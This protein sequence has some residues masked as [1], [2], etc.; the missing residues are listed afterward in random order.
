MKKQ[1]LFT[2]AFSFLIG[3]KALALDVPFGTYNYKNRIELLTVVK[4]EK[5][6]AGNQQGQEHLA[7]LRNE[8]WTCV[9]Q[10]SNYY[11]CKIFSQENQLPTEIFDKINRLFYP[12]SFQFSDIYAADL[13][14][15]SDVIDQY[16]ISQDVLVNDEVLKTYRLDYLKKRDLTKMSFEL[17]NS[18]LNYFYVLDSKSIATM[19]NETQEAGNKRIDYVVQVVLEK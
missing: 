3:L 18:E 14:N 9:H 4:F 17:K 8:G 2:V 12:S 11:R 19:H 16:E 13:V 6:Y 5:V 10:N 7:E 1:I 15:E